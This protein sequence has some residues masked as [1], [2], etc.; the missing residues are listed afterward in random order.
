M[1][2][3]EIINDL[4]NQIELTAG[5]VVLYN[6]TKYTINTLCDKYATLCGFIYEMNIWYLKYFSVLIDDI[7]L[8]KEL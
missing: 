4:S 1:L 7:K 6:N 5:D 3:Y 8:I 2:D